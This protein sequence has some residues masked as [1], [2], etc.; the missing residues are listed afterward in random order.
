MVTYSQL[1]NMD[2][3]KL[4]GAAEA[5]GGLSSTLS[6]RA[7]EVQTSAQIPGGMWAGVDAS[8]ASG[9]LETQPSPLFDASDVFRS[10]RA[11]L[12][13]LVVDLEAA[14]TK[15]T[16]AQDL[17]AGTGI[18]IGPD[19]TVTTPVVESATAADRN[20]QLAQQAR[21]LIDE[22]LKLADHADQTAVSTLTTAGLRM[23]APDFAGPTDPGIAAAQAEAFRKTLGRLPMSETD[24]Q[25][26]AALDPT[27][28]LDKNGG[29]DAVVA[30]GRITPRPGE[31]LVRIGLYIPS[32]E[33]FNLPNYD[34]GDNRGMNPNFS[35]EDTRVTLYVD[36]ETGTVLARQNP[37]VDTSGE[38]RVGTPEVQ[39]Q[40]STNGAVRIQYDAANPFA[41]PGSDVTGHSVKGDITVTPGTGDD[42][43]RIDGTIGDY[44]AFEAYH[45]TNDGPTTTIIQD[46]ADNEG[47]FGPLIELPTNHEIGAGQG[48]ATQFQQWRPLSGE[49]WQV[50]PTAPPAPSIDLGDPANPPKATPYEPFGGDSV[51]PD[52]PGVPSGGPMI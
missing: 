35:P 1:V 33:V 16:D 31:G 25:L 34:K 41:P 2:T 10:S 19:G 46:P 7:G 3:S 32:S 5:A 6:T 11:A 42:A 14:K 26:A 21:E 49:Y 38:V 48:P 9:L 47:T 12:E 28:R 15:L 30:V 37:S 27:S 13:D 4:S 50:D 18:T 29:Q 24:W 36:Y 52:V 45:D 8:A 20:A 23:N 44:P 43:P 17:V 51:H 22:A 40:E 39:V